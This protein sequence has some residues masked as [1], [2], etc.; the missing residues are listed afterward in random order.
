[1]E[2][3]LG[4][5]KAFALSAKMRVLI[6]VLMECG[7]GGSPKTFARPRSLRVLILVLMEYGLGVDSIAHRNAKPSQS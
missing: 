1:M 2:Y 4:A 7:L 3:G 5:A 6:L